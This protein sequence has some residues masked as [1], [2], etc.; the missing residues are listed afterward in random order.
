MTSRG[1]GT[2]K[3]SQVGGW[4][5]DSWWG[6]LLPPPQ[7]NAAIIHSMGNN[8]AVGVACRRRA[9]CG[10]GSWAG[11]VGSPWPEEVGVGAL[12]ATSPWS[13]KWLARGS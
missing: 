6:P 8:G 4:L 7:P 5:P 2:C 3:D 13:L 12:L 9:V 10:W 11:Q 1:T